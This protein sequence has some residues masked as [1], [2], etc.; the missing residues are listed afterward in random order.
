[1]GTTRVVVTAARQRSHRGSRRHRFAAGALVIGTLIAALFTVGGAMTPAR[2]LAAGE[3][4]IDS[5]STEAVLEPDGSMT[6]TEIV[7]YTFTDGPF[8]VGIRSFE[9]DRDRIVGF[10]VSDAEGALDVVAPDRTPTGEWEWSFRRPITSERVTFT[11]RYRVIDAVVVHIDVADLLWQFVG[12]DHPGIGTLRVVVRAPGGIPPA[13]ETTP[14]DDAGVIRGFA[15]GPS[16]G[17]LDVAE[18][19]VSAVVADVPAGRFV[20][21]RVVTPASA[22]P[23]RATG[24]VPALT[25]ILAEERAL[26]DDARD[27]QTK[28]RIGWI[29][30]PILVLLAA[31]GTTLVWLRHGRERRS[32]EVLGDY[33]RE[34]LDDPPAVAAAVLRRGSVDPGRTIAG[35]LVDLAQRGYLQISAERHE[36]VGP[37]QVVHRYRWLGKEF[38]S[39]IVPYERA[40]VEMIFRGATETTSADVQDW[41]RGNQ[42][43]AKSLLERITGGVTAELRT[44]GYADTTHGPAA[45]LLAALCVT[46]VIAAFALRAISGNG[47][48]YVAIGAGLVLFALG[49]RL[50]SNRTQAGAETAAKAEGLRRYIADFSQLEDAPVGHLILWE[51]YLVFA[52]A[53]GVSAELVRNMSVRVPQVLD[54]PTFAVWYIGAGRHF[55]GFERIETGGSEIAAASS[56]NSAGSGGSFSG[57]GGGGGGGGGFGAR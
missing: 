5:L 44:R 25:T 47:F 9:R 32:T 6:V 46:T 50:L 16:N 35:T 4:T 20:E 45:A 52:V 29:G 19:T 53:L 42:T 24:S 14:D 56:P 37:D 13:R 10:S 34:P 1:M 55:D 27:E 57:G 8:T 21:L 18:S 51:R 28:R 31:A 48:A 11:L 17:V 49:L 15:H 26:I 22:F 38:A 43:Q 12:T 54:D 39:D 33:W 36:R 30:T 40:V 2:A 7:T 3:F 23:G 41:A